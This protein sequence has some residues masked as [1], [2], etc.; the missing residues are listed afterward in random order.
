MMNGP[1]EVRLGRSSCE[2]CEQGRATG[3]GVGGAKDRDQGEHGT[4]A[5]A[6][7]AEPR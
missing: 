3:G 7:D 5:H 4:T 6:T 1:R 2:T